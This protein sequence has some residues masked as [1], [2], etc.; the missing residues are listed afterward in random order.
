MDR[1]QNL[2]IRGSLAFWLQTAAGFALHLSTGQRRSDVHRMTWADYDW[3][4][5]P[6]HSAEDGRQARL[7]GPSRAHI[8]L[9]PALKSKDMIRLTEFGSSFTLVGYGAW[10][11]AAIW[12]AA[13]YQ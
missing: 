4:G 5:D 7:S 6:R 1:V 12:A 3:E 9:Y 11:N 2:S 8:P 13:A 10:I